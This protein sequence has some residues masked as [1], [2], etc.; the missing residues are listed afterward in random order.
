MEILQ[1]ACN[2]VNFKNTSRKAYEILFLVIHY[3]G[4]E[5]D[6]AK[7]NADYSA[8]EDTGVSAHYFVDETHIYQSVQDADVAWHCGKDY[9]GGRAAYWGK[10]KNSNSI[11]VEIC[12]LDKNGTLRQGSIDHAATLVR[13]LMDKYDIDAAH[14]IRHYDVCHKQCPAPMVEYGSLWTAF[15]AT[16]EDDEV[17]TNKMMKINGKNYTVPAILKDGKNYVELH[18]LM[19]AGY[20]VSYDAD[21]KTPAILAPQTRAEVGNADGVQEA[22]DKIQAATGFTENTMAYLLNYLYGDEL[23]RKLAAMNE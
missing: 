17:V 14:V 10:C 6:T 7:N 21:T 2:S 11:G 15:K 4:N 9:S 8:R 1:K 12:M 18:S 19:Q 20:A 3:T 5:G 13:Y 22:I 23:L 16:L